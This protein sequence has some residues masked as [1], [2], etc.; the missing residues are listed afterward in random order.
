MLFRHLELPE[1]EKLELTSLLVEF[2]IA[3]TYTGCQQ[4]VE[5]DPQER[6]DKIEAIVGAQKLSRFL[7][8]EEKMYEYGEIHFVDCVLNNNGSSLTDAQQDRL[9]EIIVEIAAREKKLPRFGRRTRVARV[10]GVPPIRV[11][12]ANPTLSR[13]NR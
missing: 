12:R 7:S 10:P 13:A 2:S 6:S 8:L 5:I 1:S 9:F 3:G 11:K 4:G